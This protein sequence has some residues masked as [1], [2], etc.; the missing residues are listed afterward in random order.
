MENAAFSFPIITTQ[1]AAMQGKVEICGVNTSRLHVLSQVEMDA[2]L[3]RAQAGD[4]DAREKLFRA[5]RQ[6]RSQRGLAAHALKVVR[7][8]KGARAKGPRSLHKL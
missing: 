6:K 3:R 2:L 5:R 4:E 8:T 1:E 7:A